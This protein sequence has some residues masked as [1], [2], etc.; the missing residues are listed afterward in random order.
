MIIIDTN[1]LIRFFTNDIPKQAR[2]VEK[3]LT[4]QQKIKI[5]DSVLPEIEYILGQEYQSKRL[6]ITE[7]YQ[8]LTARKNFILSKTALKAIKIFKK[9]KLDM[10]DCLIA[11]EALEK[12]NQLASFDQEL[13]KIQGVKSYF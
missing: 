12:E 7:A 5:P 11:A 4:S 10:A 3:L 13:L 2:Q 8:L 9:S 6:Q 1:C